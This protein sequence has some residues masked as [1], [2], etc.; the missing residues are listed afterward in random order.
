[1]E[2]IEKPKE[3]IDSKYTNYENDFDTFTEKATP[4]KEL[5]IV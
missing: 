4:E 3:T 1:V 5:K 2:E